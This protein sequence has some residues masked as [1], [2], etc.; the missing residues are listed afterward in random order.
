MTDA[1]CPRC[2]GLRTSRQKRV[3]LVQLLLSKMGYFPWEC[4]GCRKVFL[5]RMRGPLKRK[6]RS[7][8]EVHLPPV[9]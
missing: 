1:L 5:A 6:R 8:G 9:G 2:K 7:E 4:G 3:G